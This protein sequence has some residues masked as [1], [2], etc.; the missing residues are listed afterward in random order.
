MTNGN[1]YTQSFPASAATGDGWDL[2]NKSIFIAHDVPHDN[3]A[4]TNN[5]FQDF[6]GENIWGGGIGVST[7]LIQGNTIKNFNGDG[8]SVS[9]NSLEVLNN[10]I[11]SGF[12]AVENGI[13]QAN[14]IK[15]IFQGNHISLMRG[16]GITLVSEDTTTH[17]GR[18]QILDNTFDTIGEII[19]APPAEAI[20]IGLGSG[21][22]LIANVT[23]E[24]NLCHDCWGFILPNVGPNLLVQNNRMSIDSY[25]GASFFEFPWELSNARVESNRSFLT[26]NATANGKS[27]TYIYI[28]TFLAPANSLSWTNDVFSNNRWQA[29]NSIY[30][31]F[32]TIPGAGFAA[33]KDK[34]IIWRGDSCDGC[35]PA[36]SVNQGGQVI[37][38][39][40]IIEP[41]G[42]MVRLFNGSGDTAAMTID[43]SREQ[44]SSELA[45]QNASNVTVTFSTDQ[46]LQLVTPVTLS[47]G[48]TIKFR[49]SEYDSKW[50]LVSQ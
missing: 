16:S 42:P 6:K 49:F 37:T 32:A 4:I 39:G 8:I 41:Y 36:Q 15:Q 11:S 27:L 24:R 22:T 25:N 12:T 46:N 34:N 1:T 7:L 44:D 10:T 31:E 26:A 29:N 3:L 9:A 5:V 21:L 14:L 48:N 13:F 20:Y 45:I 30:Y 33:L 17:Q 43:G 35:G 19:Q 50:H 47:A 40:G 38:D 23:I 18:F 28:L 2:T